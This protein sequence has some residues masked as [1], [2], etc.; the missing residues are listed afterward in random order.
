MS[1]KDEPITVIVSRRVK[2]E[3]VSEFESLTTEM[4]RRASQFEGYLGT[5]LFKPT[6]ID[7]PEYRIMFKFKDRE[8]L[9]TWE[10]SLQRAEVLVKIEA[11]L[12]SKSEREQISGLITW[13]SLPS[14]NPLTPPPRF[15]MTVISWLACILQLRLSFGY[16]GLG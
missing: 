15:K 11:L 16:L 8:S 6:A 12:I 9:N 3:K 4:T 7:D 14:T 5:T 1:V 2:A 10:A 13:F